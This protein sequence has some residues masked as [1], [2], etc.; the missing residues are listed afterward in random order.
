MS[1][2][3]DTEERN[4]TLAC[5]YLLLTILGFTGVTFFMKWGGQK[6]NSPLGLASVLFIASSVLTAV[7][8]LTGS[9]LAFSKGILFYG[10]LAGVGGAVALVLFAHALQ[11]GH[12]G[13]SVAILHMSCLIPVIFSVLFLDATLGVT[14]GIGLSSI[15]LGLFLITSSTASS[16]SKE[17]K[18]WIR[19]LIFI[20]SAFFL[21][22]IPQVAQSLVAKAAVADYAPFLFINYFSGA[23]VLFLVTLRGRHF[24]VPTIL[25]GSGGAVGSV[26]GYACVLKSLEFLKP[27][28]VFPISL[29]GPVVA[30]TMLSRLFFRERISRLGYVGIV[31]GITGIIILAL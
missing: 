11:I 14:K 19:W 3:R 21:N 13:F 8:F 23:I 10:I 26:L 30:A 27:P 22:G 15:L 7:P 1:R 5:F 31:C 9:S 20:S 6:G 16:E 18:H 24:N 28:V 29:N 2:L 4:T 25:F 17:S 12:Y